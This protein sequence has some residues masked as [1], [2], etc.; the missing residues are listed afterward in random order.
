MQTLWG[1]TGAVA[2]A[3]GLDMA[4]AILVATAKELSALHQ[5]NSEL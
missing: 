5:W 1:A 4:A 2:A 3:D